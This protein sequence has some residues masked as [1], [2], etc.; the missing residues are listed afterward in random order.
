MKFEWNEI[1][2]REDGKILL[3]NRHEKLFEE[4]LHKERAKALDVGGWGVLAQR[5]IEE[6]IDTT[7]VDIFGPDQYY[8]ERVRSLKHVVGDIT[9]PETVSALGGK[10][11]YDLITCFE[12]LEHCDNQKEAIYNMYQ[13]LRPNGVLVGT[14]PI[15]GFSHAADEP[16]INWLTPPEIEQL[17]FS[18]GFDFIEIE[19][20]ASSTKDGQ[21]TNYYFKGRKI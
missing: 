15:P 5:L 7:I 9:K 12:M 17:L 8:P 20:I 21:A 11:S 10:Y 19:P 18:C 2:R 3:L 4:G 14:V 13:L 1:K 16:G 6:G